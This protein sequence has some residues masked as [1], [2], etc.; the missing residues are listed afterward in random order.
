MF[1]FILAALMSV[2]VISMAASADVS[3]V[4]SSMGPLRSKP[5]RNLIC[6]EI[7]HEFEDQAGEYLYFGRLN[8]K[9]CAAGKFTVTKSV[10]DDTLKT[11]TL[12]DVAFETAFSNFVIK[13]TSR[14]GLNISVDRQGL[15]SKSWKILE[16][17]VAV[18][19]SR[20]VSEVLQDYFKFEKLDFHNGS[21]SLDPAVAGLTTKDLVSDLERML[22]DGEEPDSCRYVNEESPKSAL[23][24]LKEY[25]P[26]LAAYLEPKLKTGEILLAVSRTYDAGESEYCSHYFFEIV[27][28]DGLRVSLQFDFTT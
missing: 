27:T 18:E 22:E 10:Y 11:T 20:S 23:W 6:E 8:Q 5:L 4:F 26:E 19:D 15:I 24:Y 14:I 2:S 16:S 13:G 17:N 28:K 9:D 25:A 3:T 12:L 21:Y 7:R 1:G